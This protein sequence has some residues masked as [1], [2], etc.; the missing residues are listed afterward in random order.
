MIGPAGGEHETARRTPS[1]RLEDYTRW[2]HLVAAMLRGGFT[3]EEAGKVA[4]GN[5][6]RIFRTTVG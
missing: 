2:V 4:G 5:Y 3:A 1:C 6:L